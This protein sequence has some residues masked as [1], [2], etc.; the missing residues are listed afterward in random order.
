MTDLRFL[1]AGE[2][3]G[4]ALV[5][6]LEG[7]PAGL[8]LTEEYLARDLRRR[9]GGYGRS[10]RQQLEQDRAEIMGG[11]GAGV[12]ARDGGARGYRSDLP[13]LPRRVRHRGPLAHCFDRR[14]LRAG[15]LQSRLDVGGRIGGPLRRS[16]SE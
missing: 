2:S 6:M 14:H 5:A 1:T 8:P 4:K 3:H 16:G 15:G 7:V 13:P 9:Q 10:K 11:V 12:G